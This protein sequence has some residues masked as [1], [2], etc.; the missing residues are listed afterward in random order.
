[1]Q[2]ARAPFGGQ[3]PQDGDKRVQMTAPTETLQLAEPNRLRIDIV[4]G[5]LKLVTVEQFR[6]DAKRSRWDSINHSES[7]VPL[8]HDAAGQTY[9]EVVPAQ[10]GRLQ[11]AVLG[12]F[13]DAAKFHRALDVYVEPSLET[14]Q[15]NEG[16]LL[17]QSHPM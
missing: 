11:L 6:W 8:L 7:L 4:T 9:I 12:V 10:P 2:R 15:K 16:I 14:T 17:S 1:M 5:S 3:L 13:S